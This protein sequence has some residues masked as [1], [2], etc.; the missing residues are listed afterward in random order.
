[1]EADLFKAFFRKPVNML[2]E[3][4]QQMMAE[5]TLSDELTL[6]MVGGFSKASVMPS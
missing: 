4:Q 2:V 3:H 5:D 6:L 1:M